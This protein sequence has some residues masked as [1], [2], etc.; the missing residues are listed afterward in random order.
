ME[1][2]IE[3]TKEQ[4]CFVILTPGDCFDPINRFTNTP[5]PLR[6]NAKIL[7]FEESDLR[8]GCL[9]SARISSIFTPDVLHTMFHKPNELHHNERSQ[10]Y[11]DDIDNSLTHMIHLSKL[12]GIILGS[13]VLSPGLGE[14]QVCRFVVKP[15][16]IAK[17]W[18]YLISHL[19]PQFKPT[20]IHGVA[21]AFR[22]ISARSP[23][24]TPGSF[25]LQITQHDLY[26]I[27]P[28][29]SW[30][31]G[32]DG[33]KDGL[34]WHG[35]EHGGTCMLLEPHL[36]V[37]FA[38]GKGGDLRLVGALVSAGAI[39]EDHDR[40]PTSPWAR[41]MDVL[42]VRHFQNYVMGFYVYLCLNM[43]IF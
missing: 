43:H 17:A 4:P 41:S 37:G 33:T 40:H 25:A 23:P 36:T 11:G 34:R 13:M 22:R 18:K 31:G 15:A 27:P 39:T 6:K 42:D 7:K 26:Y 38:M 30:S 3:P 8:I 9:P 2:K 19:P 5:Y 16:K 14:I 24:G 10:S 32:S 29:I 20:S 28:R 21:T 1:D 35:H 12:T